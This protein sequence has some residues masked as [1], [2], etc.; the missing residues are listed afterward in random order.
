MGAV[1]R[2]TNQEELDH[3]NL[4]PGDNIRVTIKSGSRSVFRT[5]SACF[6]FPTLDGVQLRLCG[7]SLIDEVGWDQITQILF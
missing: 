5:I 3:S 6:I 7:H 4:K 1:R 2:I